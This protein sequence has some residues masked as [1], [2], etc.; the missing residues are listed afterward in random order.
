M[1][2]CI[3]EYAF[4]SFGG[5]AFKEKGHDKWMDKP[6][7]TSVFEAVSKSFE[8]AEYLIEYGWHH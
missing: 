1:F 7:S 4:D 2:P 6:N 5:E 8:D 3:P